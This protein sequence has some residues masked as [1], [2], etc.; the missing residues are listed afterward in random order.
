MSD[1]REHSRYPS[2]AEITEN[3]KDM[4][5]T[6]YGKVYPAVFEM[7]DLCDGK[8]TH[9][10]PSIDSHGLSAED[11]AADPDFAESYM[12]GDYDV[13]CSW[14]KGK[15]VVMVPKDEAGKTALQEIVTEEAEYRAEVAAERRMGA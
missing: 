12:K 15:R 7:C 10:N 14:C 5:I 13:P 3:E 4:T 6:I 8:G 1:A 11:F 2:H 9:V